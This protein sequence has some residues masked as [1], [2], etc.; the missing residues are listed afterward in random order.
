MSD[1]RVKCKVVRNMHEKHNWLARVAP[2]GCRIGKRVMTKGGPMRR[3]GKKGNLKPDKKKY[4]VTKKSFYVHAMMPDGSIA[5]LAWDTGATSTSLNHAVAK[6]LGL[7][8]S[9]GLPTNTYQHSAVNVMTADESKHK[10]VQFRNA[11][12]RIREAN[13]AAKG[14]AIVRKR[15]SLLYGVTHMRAVRRHMK[16]K[17]AD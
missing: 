13:V 3:V 4:K 8:D 9:N 11:P 6:K 16:V 12:L 2:K 5:K 14:G 7:I 15:A 10:G 17:Y 1:D